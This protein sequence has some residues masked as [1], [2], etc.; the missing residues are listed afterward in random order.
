MR[1]LRKPPVCGIALR[2]LRVPLRDSYLRTRRSTLSDRLPDGWHTLLSDRRDGR[3]HRLQV[4]GG[5][6][7]SLKAFFDICDP[8]ADGRHSA[9]KVVT[10]CRRRRPYFGASM[11]FM[12]SLVA[13]SHC[14]A[15]WL[16]EVAMAQESTVRN[17]TAWHRACANSVVANYSRTSH[18]R[19]HQD[20]VSPCHTSPTVRGTLQNSASAL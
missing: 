8:L 11:S 2:G 5:R 10:V 15:T 19:R 18:R 12:A 3:Q 6:G 14:R 9:T 13:W 17:S 1:R 7:L 20:V 16:T 4:I